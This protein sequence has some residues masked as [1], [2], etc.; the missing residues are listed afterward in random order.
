MV[1]HLEDF[2]AVVEAVQ[3]P[4]D[5]T[6]RLN[7]TMKVPGLQKDSN[8]YRYM[9]TLMTSLDSPGYEKGLRRKAG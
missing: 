7:K 9:M 5:Q 6:R 4:D 2:V 8:K 3:R 1:A